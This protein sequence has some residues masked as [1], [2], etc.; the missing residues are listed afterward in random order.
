MILLAIVALVFTL[1][2]PKL[3][4]NS[5]FPTAHIP[6]IPRLIPFVF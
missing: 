1:G 3:M 5:T 6:D 4:E 2:M